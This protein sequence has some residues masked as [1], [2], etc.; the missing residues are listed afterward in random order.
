MGSTVAS[1]MGGSLL[2][3]AFTGS[4]G[5]AEASACLTT[6]T[7]RGFTDAA[8]SMTPRVLKK[9]RKG[10]ET[11]SA[12]VYGTQGALFDTAARALDLERAAQLAAELRSAHGSSPGLH[13]VVAAADSHHQ[14]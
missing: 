5:G 13:L 3:S 9:L 7:R 10:L 14:H 6:W 4:P 1:R 8:V 2:R 11:S 12:G